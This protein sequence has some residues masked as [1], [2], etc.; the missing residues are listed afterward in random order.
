[1]KEKPDWLKKKLNAD[2]SKLSEIKVMLRSLR[3]HTV[4]EGE[5]RLA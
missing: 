5:T 1:M 2:R 4:C 3:L